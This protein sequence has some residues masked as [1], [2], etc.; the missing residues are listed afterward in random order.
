MR[1]KIGIVGV[2]GVGVSLTVAIAQGAGQRSARLLAPRVADDAE[3]AITA[4][5]AAEPLPQFPES[6][7][8]APRSG[9]NTGQ[10]NWLQGTGSNV[11]VVGGTATEK[12]QPR[13]I[14]PN[15]NPG[16][17]EPSMVSRSFDKLKS[18]FSTSG[19]A[20]PTTNTPAGA[21]QSNPNGPFRGVGPGGQ[22]VYAGPPAYRWYGWGSVTPGANPYAPNG[23][24]PK[25]SANWYSITGATPGAFPTQV[26]DPYKLGAGTEPPMYVAP[27]TSPPPGPT[28]PQGNTYTPQ[29]MTPM[30]RHQSG[31][32]APFTPRAS[33]IPVGPGIPAGTE[34]PRT[35]PA[36]PVDT[37]SAPPPTISPLPT[38][39]VGGASMPVIPAG[40]VVMPSVTSLPVVSNPTPTPLPVMETEPAG[41]KFVVPTTGP[42]TLAPMTPV[43]TLSLP[44][45]P[46]LPALP[47]VATPSETA[48]VPAATGNDV[49]SVPAPQPLPVSVTDEPKWQPTNAA[50]AAPARTQW[51]PAGK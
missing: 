50:P 18:V 11:R 3:A 44:P 2:L 26:V 48:G 24:F 35:S 20:S 27:P 9:R 34:Q 51:N 12:P 33:G 39:G 23:H 37:R 17:P 19:P 8:V 43:P 40:P 42:L 28:T 38:V 15:A 22:P 14:N 13:P 49:K 10:T 1:F 47:P 6:T 21:E 5:A 45:L 30:P 41:S 36:M 25:A 29:M 16:H 46:T 7:P 32:S 31:M 4:R